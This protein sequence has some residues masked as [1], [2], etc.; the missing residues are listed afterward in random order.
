MLGLLFKSKN[1]YLQPYNQPMLNS[2][3][4]ITLVISLLI[5]GHLLQAQGKRL[6][7]DSD[8]GF[9]YGNM[10]KH[11]AKLNLPSLNQPSAGHEWRMWFCGQYTSYVL[12]L[13]STESK[14]II[15][16][17]EY[18][19]P[20]T[21]QPS[22]KVFLKTYALSNAQIRDIDSLKKVYGID[23]IPTEK[24][25][26]GWGDVMGLDGVTYLIE[27]TDD[28]TF[29]FKSYWSPAAIK[30]DEAKK[31]TRF[32]SNTEKIVGYQQCF[33]DFSDSNTFLSYK[34]G[35]PGVAM[36]ILPRKEARRLR[37]AHKA[38]LRSYPEVGKQ[39]P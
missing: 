16:T 11:A 38:Y 15:Y 36:K 1:N 7:A 8:T 32:I 27:Q 33:T 30:T 29:S 22:E 28:A 26:K 17:C 34:T 24:Q 10:L 23:Q 3:K 19:D 21:W 5:Q 35:G 2:L 4:Y 18:Q 25:I 12:I 20:I 9:W 14:L 13:N 37:K 31:I 6:T 39:T